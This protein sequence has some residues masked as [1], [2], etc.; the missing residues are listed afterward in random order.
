[1]TFNPIF[2]YLKNHSK[3]QQC[4]NRQKTGLI[5]TYYLSI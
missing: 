4:F 3:T 1:V 5:F 2:C